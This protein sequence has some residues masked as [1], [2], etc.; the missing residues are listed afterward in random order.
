MTPVN[1]HDLYDHTELVTRPGS[2]DPPQDLFYYMNVIGS[3]QLGTAMSCELNS[4]IAHL[5]GN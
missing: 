2:F 3:R 5:H 4:I 1:A